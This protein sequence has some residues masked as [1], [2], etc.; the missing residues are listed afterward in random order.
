MSRAKKSPKPLPLELAE[1]AADMSRHL[2]EGL[3]TSAVLTPEHIHHLRTSVKRLR[4]RWHLF[5][6]GVGK[7]AAKEADRNLRDAA[8]EFSGARD[9]QVQLALLRELAE[10]GTGKGKPNQS[11]LRLREAMAGEMPE[12]TEDFTL[13]EAKRSELIGRFREDSRHWSQAT[14]VAPGTLVDG[15]TRVFKKSQLLAHKAYS[16]DTPEAFH[17]WRKWAKYL[18]YQLE[19][20]SDIQPRW[21]KEQLMLWKELGSNLGK[22]HDLSILFDLLEQK[23]APWKP[24]DLEITRKRAQTLDDKLADRC[25]ILYGTLYGESTKK[26]RLRTAERM[27]G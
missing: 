24:R 7:M 11:V 21:K 18:Y 1:I 22:R 17:Q 26:F 16:K 8:K 14:E 5:R 2:G 6:S 3:E 27:L 20:L 4:S 23:K 9:A 19:A 13:D 25:R 12:L 15:M 10:S